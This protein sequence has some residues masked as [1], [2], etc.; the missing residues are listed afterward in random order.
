MTSI[1][2]HGR[3]FK[4]SPLTLGDLRKLEPALLGAE[5]SVAHGFASML[6]LV[7]VIHASLSKLHPE[8]ALEELEQMLDLNSFAEV[9]DRVLHVSGLKRAGNTAGEKQPAAE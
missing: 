2:L 9:L 3:E 4:L 1:S 7:P 6:A 8:L 5:H